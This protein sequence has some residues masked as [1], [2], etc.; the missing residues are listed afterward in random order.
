[1]GNYGRA[2]IKAV[3]LYTTGLAQSPGDAWAK[4]ITE[5]C[6]S[7]S[8]QTKG[9]PKC[10]FLGL[11]KEGKIRGISGSNYTSSLRNK[12]YA[13]DAVAILKQ[14][15]SLAANSRSLW[16]AVTGEGSKSHNGQ[17]DVVI[18]LSKAGYLV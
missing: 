5:A 4:A 9:C 7:M 8:S 17:M 3:E 14:N 12:K 1:M 18:S 16:N 11:C 13:V 10:A 2:A 15:P 6:P